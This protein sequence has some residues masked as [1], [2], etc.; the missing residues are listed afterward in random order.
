M[1]NKT[2]RNQKT[3]TQAVVSVFSAATISDEVCVKLQ[4]SADEVRDRLIARSKLHGFISHCKH[5]QYKGPENE[6]LQGPKDGDLESLGRS[7]VKTNFLSFHDMFIILSV[8]IEVT[9]SHTLFWHDSK[10]VLMFSWPQSGED[11]FHAPVRPD[12]YITWRVSPLLAFYQKRFPVYGWIRLLLHAAFIICS[13]IVELSEF[14]A[15]FD[16]CQK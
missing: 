5:H 10:D 9:E 16:C 11:S 1:Q 8:W 14:F 12:E 7:N 2:H 15:W 4:G 3:Q 13:W 6:T